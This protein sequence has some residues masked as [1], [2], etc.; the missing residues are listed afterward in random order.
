MIS[1]VEYFTGLNYYQMVVSHPH[2]LFL[3]MLL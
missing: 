1:D 3:F 2:I